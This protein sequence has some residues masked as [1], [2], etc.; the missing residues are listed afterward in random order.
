MAFQEGSLQ[1]YLCPL[2]L[3]GLLAASLYSASASA[4][5]K[6]VSL[7]RKSHCDRQLTYA[8]VQSDSALYAGRVLEMKGVV[9]G[10]AGSGDNVSMMLALADKST[11]VLD[12]PPAEVVWLRD[13]VAPHVRV[14]VKVG[15]AASGNVIPLTVLA[16]AHEAEV[17]AIEQQEAAREAAAA[18]REAWRAQEEA[19]WRQQAWRSMQARQQATMTSRGGYGRGA[20]G[21]GDAYSLAAAYQPY[22]GPRVKSFFVPYYTFISR[23]NAR[24]SSRQVGEITFNLLRFSDDQNVDPRLVVSMIIAESGFN[25]DATSRCGAMGLGQLMPGT[26]RAL[27]I[28]NPYNAAQNLAGSI[29]YLRGRLD[30][31]GWNTAVAM[32]AYNAGLGAVRKY[33]GVPPYRETKAYVQRVLSIYKALGGTP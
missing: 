25:P 2:L 23:Y 14:L 33:G 22:L 30:A 17:G 31:C 18:R 4:G 28:N 27:G 29:A 1:K 15:P 26:A 5:A 13:Y 20:Q 16:I 7:R 10:T 12:L 21:G 11:V 3:V 8:K 24:L 9:G 19:R 6:Y 32:A